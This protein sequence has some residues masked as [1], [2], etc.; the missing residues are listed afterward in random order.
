MGNEVG[1]RP[2]GGQAESHS[3]PKPPGVSGRCFFRD[4]RAAHSV[5]MVAEND[6]R[7]SCRSLAGPTVNRHF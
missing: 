7:A 2:G 4:E 6:R 3:N 5:M 1:S